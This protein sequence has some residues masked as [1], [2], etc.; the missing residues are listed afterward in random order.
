MCQPTREV[1]I[2]NLPAAICKMQNTLWRRRTLLYAF[3]LLSRWRRPKSVGNFIWSV[4]LDS[5]FAWHMRKTWT[6]NFVAPAITQCQEIKLNKNKPKVL[7]QSNLAKIFLHLYISRTTRELR[8]A[9]CGEARDQEEPCWLLF[10]LSMVYPCYGKGQLIHKYDPAVTKFCTIWL[11]D[12]GRAPTIRQDIEDYYWDRSYKA[13]GRWYPLRY[14]C[15]SPNAADSQN[16]IV[17]RHKAAWNF[18]D[19]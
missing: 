11:G 19:S 5:I 10:G 17:T 14:T 13:N 18:Q 9:P 3:L 6:A 16:P 4:T 12:A 8:L 1:T 15:K 7:Y 2:T